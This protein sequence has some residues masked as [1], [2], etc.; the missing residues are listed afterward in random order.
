MVVCR[1]L[2]RGGLVEVFKHLQGGSNNVGASQGGRCETVQKLAGYSCSEC[3]GIADRRVAVSNR[4]QN[5]HKKLIAV[6]RLYAAGTRTN[7]KTGTEV[8]RFVRGEDGTAGS[9]GSPPPN[10]T[11]TLLRS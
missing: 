2:H 6:K 7:N 11:Q 3:A 8:D 1:V 4:L 10:L 9:T 5:T